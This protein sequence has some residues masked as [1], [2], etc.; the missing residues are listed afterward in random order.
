MLKNTLNNI[1]YVST[2]MFSN[3]GLLQFKEKEGG[4]Y[5]K[6]STVKYF[7][8]CKQAIEQKGMTFDHDFCYF[9]LLFSSLIS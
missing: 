7:S 8:Y 9:I 1:K 6:L 5:K 3:Y 4:K 2:L